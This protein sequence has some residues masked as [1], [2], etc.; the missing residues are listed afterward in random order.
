MNQQYSCKE[1]YCDQKLQYERE[2]VKGNFEVLEVLRE[3]KPRIVY[4]TCP[5]GHTHPY[6]ITNY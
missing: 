2:V 4:L 1:P 3:Q 5:K 6:Q